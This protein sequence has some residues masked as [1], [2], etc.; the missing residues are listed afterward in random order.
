VKLNPDRFSKP[1]RISDFTNYEQ[2]VTAFATDAFY[3]SYQGSKA[4]STYYFQVQ[5]S[6]NGVYTPTVGIRY[7]Y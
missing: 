2:T 5:A 4:L 1:V 6:A 3:Q 7:C